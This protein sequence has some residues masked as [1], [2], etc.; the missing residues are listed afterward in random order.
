MSQSVAPKRTFH[1]GNFKVGLF[2]SLAAQPFEVIRTTSITSFK[3]KNNNLAGTIA[4]VKRIFQLEGT[5][6]FFR[7]GLLSLGKSTL[8][9]GVFFNGIENMHVITNRFREIKYLPNN[10]I[11]FCNAGFSRI[12]TTLAV[13]PASVLKT[14]FEVVGNNQ[15]TG[16]AHAF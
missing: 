10:V 12:F 4:V 13:S 2:I 11:D 6:G 3:S 8:G 16:I 14:R 7:G 5:R 15:Y 1:F 9:A